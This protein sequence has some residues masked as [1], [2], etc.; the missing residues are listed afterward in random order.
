MMSAAE[1]P[2]FRSLT[3]SYK[4][5]L[6]VESSCSKPNGMVLASILSFITT[7]RFA[8]SVSVR[9]YGE[10]Y[11]SVGGHGDIYLAGGNDTASTSRKSF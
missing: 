8:F 10:S 5:T 3:G 1:G 7:F 2:G 4:R 6:P 11:R 9:L